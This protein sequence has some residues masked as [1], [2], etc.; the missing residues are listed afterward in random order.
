MHQ[1]RLVMDR[2]A[3][4]FAEDVVFPHGSIRF[5]LPNVVSNVAIT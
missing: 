1:I 4:V 5:V 3:T 2:R